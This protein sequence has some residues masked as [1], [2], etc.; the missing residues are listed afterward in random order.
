[1]QPLRRALTRMG[2]PNLASTLVPESL[3]NNL[4]YSVV[5]YLKRLK[6][7]AKVEFDRLCGEV[8]RSK[9]QLIDCV[10]LI[11]RSPLRKEFLTNPALTG[12]VNRSHLKFAMHNLCTFQEKFS[13]LRDQMTDFPGFSLVLK[14]R[15]MRPQN[16]RNP[17]D[18]QRNSLLDQVARMRANFLQ[19]SL[20]HTKLQDEGNLM[21]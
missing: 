10:K 5:N 19:P 18:I 15:E 3:D 20:A 6:H 2:A 21:G 9:T 11:P 12:K 14:E 4:S 8:G 13:A 17:F 1:M 7:Q 16:L